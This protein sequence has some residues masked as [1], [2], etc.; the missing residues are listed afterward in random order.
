MFKDFPYNNIDGEHWN[1]IHIG[2]KELRYIDLD[3]YVDDYL[4]VISVK[5]DHS[6]VG[7]GTSFEED[8]IAFIQVK[9]ESYGSFKITA[10]ITFNDINGT[11]NEKHVP[12]IL[13]VY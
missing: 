3:K 6:K 10:T 8:G 5:W 13:K 11:I 4:K 1:D 7:T 2:S 9:P 12:M